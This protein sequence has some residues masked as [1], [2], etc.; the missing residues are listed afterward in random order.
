MLISYWKE[1]SEL[2]F[3][4][5]FDMHILQEQL[6]IQTVHIRFNLKNNYI[7]RMSEENS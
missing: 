6:N 4:G 1:A 7:S 3:I 2:L 5:M